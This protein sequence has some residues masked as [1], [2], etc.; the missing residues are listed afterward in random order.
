MLIEPLFQHAASRADDV[1]VID[2]TGRYTHGQIAAMAAGLGQF[3]ASVTKQDKVGLF[4][5][6][7]AAFMASFYG[8]LLARKTVV[9]INFLLGEQ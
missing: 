8:T 1:A 6:T 7:S 9:P 4:L 5:P 3:I 2:D